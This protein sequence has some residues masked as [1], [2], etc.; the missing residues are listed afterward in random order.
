MNND[1]KYMS[2]CIQ[3][4]EQALESGNPPVGSVLVLDGIIIG[5]GIESGKSSGDVTDHAEILAIRNAIKNGFG[6]HLP[7]AILYSTHEPCMMCSYVI[8]HHHIPHILFGISVEYVGG[9]TSVF[10]I[11]TTEKVPKWGKPPIV[12]MGIGREDCEMLNKKFELKK[13]KLNS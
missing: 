3:L 2:R 8:R 9:F 7:K 4:A 6:K 12:S 5:E 11:L 1:D 10:K 13:S